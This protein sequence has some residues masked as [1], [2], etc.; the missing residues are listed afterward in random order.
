MCAQD[1]DAAVAVPTAVQPA[2]RST[3]ATRGR[4]GSGIGFWCAAG[5]LA[6]VTTS[7]AA[8]SV[9][10]L[11]DPDQTLVA[12]DEAPGTGHWLGTD[13]LGRDELSRLVHAGQVSL[14]V[15][16]ASIVIALLGGLVLGLVAGYYRGWIDL[17]IGVVLDALLSFPALIVFLAVVAFLGPGLVNITVAIGVL[18]VAPIARVVRTNT[19]T[20]MNKEFVLAAQTLGM[21]PVR[22]MRREVLPNVLHSALV[23]ALVGV[24][25]AILAEGSLSFFGLSVPPPR[26]TWGG[27]VNESRTSLETDPQLL[28]WP[29]LFIFLTVLSLNVLG[30]RV[31]ERGRDRG[32]R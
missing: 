7:A 13:D 28:V 1:L 5:W 8:A 31:G 21:R 19:I 16:I 29:T 25:L 20:V 14:T 15:G 2:L 9:L 12:P 4:R 24:G 32:G 30:E 23:V 10:P 17:L 6:L 27:M 18:S 3:P 11:P 26:A 22:M